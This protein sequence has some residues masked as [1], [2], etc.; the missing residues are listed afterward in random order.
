VVNVA[1]A[2]RAEPLASKWKRR[3]VSI[4]LMLGI[5]VVAV[6]GG[7]VIIAITALYDLARMRLGLPTVRVYLFLLQYAI[8]DSVEI[9]VAPVLWMRAGFG[10]R[11]DDPAS[12]HRHERVQRWSIDVMARRA[13]QLF[14]VRIEVDE[15]VGA[16]LE[17]VPAIV[18]CRHVNLI[19]TALPSLLYHRLRYSVRGVIMAEMLADPG[20]DLLYGRLGSEFIPRDNGPQARQ[21][22]ARLAAGLDRA[23][24]AVIF[25]EGRLFRPELLRRIIER[26]GEKDP[27]RAARLAGLRHVLPPRPGGVLEL[28]A[29]CPDADVVVI[30]HVGLDRFAT[31]TDLAR[32]V[33]LREPLQVTA[34]RIPR[35][36]VPDDGASQVEWLD[37]IWCDVDDWID[38]RLNAPA[39]RGGAMSRTLPALRKSGSTSG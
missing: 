16:A 1:E 4:P 29:A 25:P 32:G 30:A 18:L 31:F 13:E 8:N 34:W 33:P 15:A 26:L 6:V 7:P 24:V 28:L 12:R 14:G 22:I 38:T 21:A 39:G 2:I 11:L 3:A 37:K 20:F 10:R 23:T 17:P 35:R 27:P 9:V 5:T 36:E 19:D